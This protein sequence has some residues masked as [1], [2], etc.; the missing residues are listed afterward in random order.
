MS[1]CEMKDHISQ[2]IPFK[3]SDQSRDIGELEFK[4]TTKPSILHPSCTFCPG[5]TPGSSLGQRGQQDMVEGGF[6][7]DMVLC[8][9][10]YLLFIELSG[11]QLPFNLFSLFISF[12]F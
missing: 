2:L 8:A 11:A 6:K 9:I 12:P 7:Q 3:A 1:R 4:K 10:V 5:L